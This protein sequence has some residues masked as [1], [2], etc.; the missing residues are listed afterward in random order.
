M[1]DITHKKVQDEEARLQFLIEQIGDARKKFTED[2]VKHQMSITT[3]VN[4]LADLQTTSTD[5]DR[6][7]KRKQGAVENVEAALSSLQQKMQ[8][9][10]DRVN[11]LVSERDDLIRVI[12]DLDT[13]K[14]KVQ[15]GIDASLRDIDSQTRRANE[16]FVTAQKRLED[17]TLLLE[18]N[19]TE[20]IRL[21]DHE[22]HLQAIEQ[23][24]V[25][26]RQLL[27]HDAQVQTAKEKSLA[28]K[29]RELIK[30]EDELYKQRSNLE[31]A[32]ASSREKEQLIT[33]QEQDINTRLREVESKEAQLKKDS[34]DLHDREQEYQ[35]KFMELNARERLVRVREKTVALP[36]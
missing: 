6:V 1:S 2:Q 17:N 25:K 8:E 27:E 36:E 12:S 33:T 31:S 35:I 28:E 9:A 26:Q 5:L 10:Q 14:I 3:L 23:D 4:K 34:K 32:K 11:T 29:E 19:K 20:A 16:V 21:R 30:M 13:T 22:V 18:I 15:S 24:L 7:I